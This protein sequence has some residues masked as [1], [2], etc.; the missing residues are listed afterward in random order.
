LEKDLD[1]LKKSSENLFQILPSN[2]RVLGRYS[3]LEYSSEDKV[4]SGIYVFPAKSS[5]AT[6]NPEFQ[7][8]EY[9]PDV[10]LSE[11]FLVKFSQEGS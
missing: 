8:S 7:S 9:F 11:N 6:I 4:A 3:V 1:N 10:W 2:K 5:F